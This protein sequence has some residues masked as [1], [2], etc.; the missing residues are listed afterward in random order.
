M[1]RRSPQTQ[2][3]RQRELAKADKRR[4]KAEKKALRKSAKSTDT[5]D[6]TEQATLEIP[7][8]PTTDESE[9]PPS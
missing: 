9:S 8:T 7:E 3:K 5:D 2:A 6:A 4:E 1:A